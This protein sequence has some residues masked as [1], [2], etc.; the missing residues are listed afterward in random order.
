MFIQMSVGNKLTTST[1][2]TVDDVFNY[3]AA[4]LSEGLLFLNFLDSVNGSFSTSL[5]PSGLRCAVSS[6]RHSEWSQRSDLEIILKNLQGKKISK[7]KKRHYG[8]FQ[9]FQRDPVLRLD[10]SEMYKWIEDHKKQ[11]ASGIKAR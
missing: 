11:I 9:N 7:L 4:L 8:H 3:N 5:T 2:Q 10:M 1:T 6:G